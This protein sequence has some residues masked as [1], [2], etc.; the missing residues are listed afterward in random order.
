MA[1]SVY[2]FFGEN[3]GKDVVSLFRRRRELVEA[4]TGVGSTTVASVLQGSHEDGG[5]GDRGHLAAQSAAD[6]VV[7]RCRHSEMAHSA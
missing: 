3:A 6:G 1:L 5:G 2:R 4:A 7:D